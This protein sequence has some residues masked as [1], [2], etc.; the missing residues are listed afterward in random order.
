MQ[1]EQAHPGVCV[2]LLLLL[3]E[4]HPHPAPCVEGICTTPDRAVTTD[5]TKAAFFI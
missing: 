3:Q 5:G 4:A 2:V 1:A